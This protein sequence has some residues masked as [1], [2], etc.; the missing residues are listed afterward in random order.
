MV[1]TAALCLALLLKRGSGQ[2]RAQGPSS[3]HRGRCVHR[4]REPLGSDRGTESHPGSVVRMHQQAEAAVPAQPSLQGQHAEID[5]AGLS[6]EQKI[7]RS[8]S[9]GPGP[10]CSTSR[11]T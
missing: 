1:L 3:P 4:F 10:T 5:E 8:S 9:L 2:A 11:R 6:A 7:Q